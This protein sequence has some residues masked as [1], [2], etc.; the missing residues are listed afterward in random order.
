MIHIFTIT[1]RNYLSLALTLGESVAKLH[2]EAGFTIVAADGLDDID[3]ML[4]PTLPENHRLIGASDILQPE[5]LADLAFK[6]NVTE[7]CTAIKPTIFKTLLSIAPNAE[8]VVYLDPDTRLYQ[9]L[10]LI[11]E[12]RSG[13]T[14][15]LTPHLADCRI[16]DT[17]PY[18]EYH[19]LWEG[20][21]NLGFCA[22]R[23]TSATAHLLDWWEA[24]LAVYCYA[25]PFDGL[26]TDQKWMDYAPSFFRD[27]LKVID[28]HGINA[29][30][31]NLSER[32]LS[33]QGDRYYVG[34]VPLVLFHFSGFDFNGK[35]LTKHVPEQAQASY[36]SPVLTTFAEDYRQT[37]MAKGHRQFLAIPYGFSSFDDG[38]PVS[39]P[40]R[41]IYRVR[42]KTRPIPEPFSSIGPFFRALDAAGLI[43]RSDAAKFNYAKSTVIDLEGK[44]RTVRRTM[45]LLLRLIGFRR[46]VQLVK[47]AAWLGRFENHEFLL[48][49]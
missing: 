33:Q 40:I 36:G 41:R 46:Y 14:L 5:K 31:W 1:A 10:D 16:A 18:P 2:P 28:H 49:E 3:G 8:V 43:D 21:F 4:P 9:R 47:L 37:V 39:Q 30:H 44:L 17:H 6:Y 22:I 32:P 34:S 45:R 20:I 24:R 13:K 29:A 11:T 25:D 26:H 12:D 19:H 15:Y 48:G 23:R 7:F 35:N 27:Q 38:T 42:S